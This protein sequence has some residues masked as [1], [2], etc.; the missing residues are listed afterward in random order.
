MWSS[1]EIQTMKNLS[2]YWSETDTQTG[3][4]TSTTTTLAALFVFTNQTHQFMIFYTEE[5]WI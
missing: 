1:V 5:A 3:L 2:K 4:A